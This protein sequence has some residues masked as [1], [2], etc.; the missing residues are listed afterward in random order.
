MTDAAANARELSPGSFIGPYRIDRLLGSG[1]MGTVYRARQVHLQRVVALKVM[2][3]TLASDEEF[4]ERFMREARAGAAIN[5]PHVVVIFDADFRDGLL[6]QVF[7]FVPGG[8]LAQLVKAR[9]PLPPVEAL[10]FVAECADGL[11]AIHQ[12]GMLHRDIKPQ[13]IFLDA[14]GRA[15]LGD[16]GLARMAAGDDKMTMTGAVMGTPAYM[17]PEQADGNDLDIRADIHALGGTLY[18]LLT[19]RPPFTGPTQMAIMGKVMYEPPPDPR[20]V[21]PSVPAEVAALVQR[22][23]AKRRDDRFASPAKMRQEA[24]RVA[25]GLP[26]TADQEPAVDP[27]ASTVIPSPTP[28]SRPAPTLEAPVPPTAQPHARSPVPRNPSPLMRRK[29]K[30]LPGLPIFLGLLL[31]A[32][33]MVGGGWWWHQ[34]SSLDAG[35]DAELE[36][37]GGLSASATESEERVV[38]E[39][40]TAYD[41][42]AAGERKAAVDVAWSKKQAEINQ[43]RSEREEKEQAAKALPGNPLAPWASAQGK[44]EYG[45]WAD[46]AVAG[47]IQ[48]FRLIPAGKF[49]MGCDDAE[50][51]AAVADWKKTFAG[52][53]RVWFVAPPHTVTLTRSFWMADST[54]TQG[55]WQAV[56]GSNPSKFTGDPQRPVEQ[57]SWNDC[58][59][60]LSA[61]NQSDGR[62]SARLPTEA[63]WEYACRAGTTGPIPGAGLD[64]IAWYR[65]NSGQM[66]HP[67][68]QK[69]PNQ[70][71]L[72]DMIGNV[73]QWCGDWYGDYPAGPVMDPVGPAISNHRVNRG[74]GWYFEPAFCRSGNR[75]RVLP[76]EVCDYLGFRICVP[77]AGP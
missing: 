27:H 9:G 47:V 69:A 61:L 12:A 32:A 65:G 35:R 3:P 75:F 51:D 42:M 13:N 72:Y 5:H 31:A 77:V 41:A 15:K 62:L 20:A 23:M 34:Q 11:Q 55:L 71:G 52:A 60:F 8:D 74:G 43:F 10:R 17:A 16:L 57:V 50:V 25:A 22:A 6:Y 4:C 66:S 7:E 24:L 19:A 64:A 49:T 18:T 1:G 14:E 56:M 63:E 33:L 40:V 58:Q 26:T 38:A 29:T 76:M 36:R 44:D 2:K 54:C 59:R 21:V 37:I 53:N 46:V 30:G 39:A 28:P 67:V 68:K 48:R 45:T 70:W 73:C